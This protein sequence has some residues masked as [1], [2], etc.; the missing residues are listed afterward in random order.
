MK[1]KLFILLAGITLSA[2]TMFKNADLKPAETHQRVESRNFKVLFNFA[3][4]F[5]M[6][7]VSLN[8]EYSLKISG[9]SAY[10]F[11]PYYGVAHTAPMN[12][13]EGGIKFEALMED[14]SVKSVPRKDESIVTFKVSQGTTNYKFT[15]SIYDNG[16]ASLHVSDFN[17]DPISFAGELGL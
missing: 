16:K 2:C 12:L 10:A 14:F 9:D 7:P 6:Q 17:R 5:R 11:L 3:Y 8:S 13:S 15:L 4:P 1:T